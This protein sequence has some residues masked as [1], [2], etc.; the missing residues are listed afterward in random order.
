MTHQF[1]PNLLSVPCIITTSA[2]IYA[3]KIS[4]HSLNCVR[5]ILPDVEHFHLTYPILIS[6][7]LAQV[8]VIC[9]WDKSSLATII[10]SAAAITTNILMTLPVIL[11]DYTYSCTA[12]S[13]SMASS[14]DFPFHFV[15]SISTI[16]SLPSSYC[17]LC[18][19]HY[20]F[21]FFQVLLLQSSHC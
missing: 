16:M 4:L 21:Q 13:K 15:P 12:A 18:L 11:R 14:N 5:G 7:D 19:R 20:F 3:K 2:V 8:L 6:N 17:R 9:P 1:D 10:P